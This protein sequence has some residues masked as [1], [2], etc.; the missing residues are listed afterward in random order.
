MTPNF[1][2]MITRGLASS[3]GIAFRTSYNIQR[4][5]PWLSYSIQTHIPLELIPTQSSD[6][7]A[8]DVILPFLHAGKSRIQ[9]RS[10]PTARRHT[11]GYARKTGHP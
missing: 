11:L 9:P 8:A 4:D 7:N 2:L 10:A 3:P 6:Q 5:R 1:Y